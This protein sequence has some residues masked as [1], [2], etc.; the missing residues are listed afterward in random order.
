MKTQPITEWVLLNKPET[1]NSDIDLIVEVWNAQGLH[2]TN[3]QIEHLKTRCSNP[4]TI[5]RIRQKLQEQGKYL[6][7]EQVENARYKKFV[8]V[9]GGIGVANA[10]ETDELLNN[11]RAIHVGLDY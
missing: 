10:Q 6:P 11:N 1:R 3:Q 2:L 7:S 5:R 4:E 9:K 8:A